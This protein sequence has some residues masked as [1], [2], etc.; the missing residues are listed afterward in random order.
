ML[1]LLDCGD[2]VFAEMV[3]GFGEKLAACARKQAEKQANVESMTET[4]AA[5]QWHQ[6]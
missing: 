1:G 3:F 4:P 6:R 2:V 5:Q